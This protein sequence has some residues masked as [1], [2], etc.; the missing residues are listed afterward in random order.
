MTVFVEYDGTK[1]CP[2]GSKKSYNICCKQ[3]LIKWGYD[4]SGKL[5]K[6]IPVSPEIGEDLK[7]AAQ[8][9][10]Q[11]YGRKPK[12]EDYIFSFSPVYQDELLFKAMQVMQSSG[13][14]PEDIYAYYKTDGLLPC[15]LNDK[16]ISEK[17]EKNYLYYRD[18]YCKTINAPL[19]N[20]I[21]SLQFTVYGNELL[22]ST[23]DKVQ[24]RLIGSLNDFI[25]RHSNDSNGIYN[26]EMKSETDYLLFSAIKTIKTIK[27]ITL[28]I[29]EQIPECIHALGR[30]LFE[31]YMYLHKINCDPNFFKMK[32]LPKVDKEH[33]QFVRKKDKTI[34]RNKVFHIETGEI[35]NIHVIIA[36]LKKSF[37]NLEDRDLYDLYYSNS[38]QYIHVDVLSAKNYFSTYDPYDELNPSLQAAIVTVSITILLYHALIHNRLVSPQFYQDG[39]Y[40]VRQLTGD[41][42]VAI[43]ILNS[44]SVHMQQIFPT[45]LKRLQTLYSELSDRT[46]EEKVDI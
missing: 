45:L 8:L 28:L 24:E 7:A 22:R 34:D 19:T 6:Q 42:L 13:I 3:K 12:Q 20:T 25:H 40:L 1:P 41:L 44:D 31:N 9:F 43:E 4:E 10:E 38:C 23:F 15:S 27:G 29:E 21:N 17:C 26:Y 14:P 11:Y 37:S 16:Y 39:S 35:Y 5:V 32:L 30:S 2:C 46:F 18:E 33:F 36:E